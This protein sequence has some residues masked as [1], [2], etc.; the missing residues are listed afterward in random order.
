MRRRDR[1]VV[2]A[3]IEFMRGS[4]GWKRKTYEKR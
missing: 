4:L 1:R 2:L 3:G